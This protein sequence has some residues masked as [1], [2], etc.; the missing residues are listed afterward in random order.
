MLLKLLLPLLA[1][2]SAAHGT[3]AD[4]SHHV[5]KRSDTL[6]CSI[7][8]PRINETWDHDTVFRSCQNTTDWIAEQAEFSLL[9]YHNYTIVYDMCATKITSLSP[10]YQV[11]NPQEFAALISREILYKCIMGDWWGLMI[12]DGIAYMVSMQPWV[13]PPPLKEL[14][15]EPV[16]Q[17]TTIQQG[18]SPG[19]LY[20]VGFTLVLS[21]KDHG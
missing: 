6:F 14:E 13:A 9:P 4:E 3:Q 12:D 19:S 5:D 18:P 7:D 20:K 11:F 16:K 21:F 17:I 15:Q 8:R 1:L 2:A 10:T